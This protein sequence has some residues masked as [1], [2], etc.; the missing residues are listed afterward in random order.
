MR[1]IRGRNTGPEKA[2]RRI[3]SSLG[4]RYRLNSPTLPG[5]PDLTLS[6][7]RKVVFVNGCF[8]HGHRCHLG[9]MPKSRIE[10]WAGKIAQNRARDKRV[11]RALSTLGWRAMVVWECQLRKS[12]R[13]SLRL[14]QFLGRAR[15]Q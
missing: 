15:A 7:S 9:R 3:I 10:F 11:L 8:W 2:V 4:H 14:R 5:R 1:L 6:T 13:L 12:E